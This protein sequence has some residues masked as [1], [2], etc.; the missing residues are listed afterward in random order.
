[1]KENGLYLINKP[2]G[3]TSH[4]MVSK[5]RR[6]TGERRIGHAGTLDPFA[7]GLL[8]I[9]VGREW[10]KRQSEFL[11][12][13]K[14]YE[15]TLILGATSDTEDC[16][17]II[18]PQECN[19]LSLHDIQNVCASFMKTYDQMPSSFSAKKINGQK[20]YDLARKGIVPNLKTQSITIHS[21]EILDYTWPNLTVR[22][23]VSSG[24]YIRAL[25]RDIGNELGCGAYVE[26]LKRTSIGPYK[27]GDAMQIDI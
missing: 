5:A 24:T 21:L 20:A 16:T 7:Q 15:A 10:T 9:L 27:L 14:T 26:N 22:V 3:S 12:M 8:I 13:D 1:M 6:I 2:A 4:D 25:A 11:H 23:H 18:T 19:P 17:G